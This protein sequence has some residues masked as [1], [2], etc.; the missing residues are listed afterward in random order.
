[1]LERLMNRTMWHIKRLYTVGSCCSNS[2]CRS[3]STVA[4]CLDQ[5]LPLSLA[6]DRRLIRQETKQPETKML[7]T[8]LY[9]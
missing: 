7:H 2:V 8:S 9:S 6:Y 3:H 4:D 5:A 1:M